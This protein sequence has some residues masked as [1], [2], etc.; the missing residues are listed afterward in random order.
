MLH[1]IK[2]S[3]K[4]F[5]RNYSCIA[6]GKQAKEN[7]ATIK[8]E[9]GEGIQKTGAIKEKIHTGMNLPQSSHRLRGSGWCINWEFIKR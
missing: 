1:G 9:N 7:L 8:K 5:D 3:I 2:K 4:S 6:P